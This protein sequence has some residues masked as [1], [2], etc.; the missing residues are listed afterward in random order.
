MDEENIAQLN[1]LAIQDVLNRTGVY[2]EEDSKDFESFNRIIW[3]DH[4]E[5]LLNPKWKVIPHDL[6]DNIYS[7]IKNEKNNRF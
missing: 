3:F 4:K 5:R 2:Y 6:G 7:N 1:M